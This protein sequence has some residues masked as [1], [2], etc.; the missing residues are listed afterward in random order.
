MR[1]KVTIESID[2]EQF[3]TDFPSNTE[4][5]DQEH[6]VIQVLVTAEDFEDEVRVQLRLSGR[7]LSEELVPGSVDSETIKLRRGTSLMD[8]EFGDPISV[9]VSKNGIVRFRE[10]IRKEVSEKKFYADSSVEKR[11]NDLH[12]RVSELEQLVE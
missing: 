8:W 5:S 10:N 4:S 11:I 12:Q 9:T 7:T 3:N 2:V 6:S 1:G